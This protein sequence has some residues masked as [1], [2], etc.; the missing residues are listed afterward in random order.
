MQQQDAEIHLAI[1][2]PGN[3]AL[4]RLQQRS[5]HDTVMAQAVDPTA[6]KIEET[7]AAGPSVPA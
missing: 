4:Q 6:A 7:A 5:G 3:G 1:V 2:K